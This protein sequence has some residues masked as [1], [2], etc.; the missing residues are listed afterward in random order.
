M[1]TPQELDVGVVHCRH[2]YLLDQGR[3][4]KGRNDADYL[5]NILNRDPS[6]ALRLHCY[7]RILNRAWGKA[8]HMEWARAGALAKRL[9]QTTEPELGSGVGAHGGAFVVQ[10]ASGT[11]QD[12]VDGPVTGLD[13][14]QK[15]LADVQRN[16]KVGLNNV[17]NLV[18]GNI[19]ERLGFPD[20]G[21]VDHASKGLFPDY[22]LHFSELNGIDQIGRD[23]CSGR[24]PSATGGIP[25]NRY[26]RVSVPAE[27]VP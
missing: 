1:P 27:T 2:H 8:G 11:N 23:H 9:S 19:K 10:A 7:L 4:G 20:P 3:L 12:K 24:K 15:G 5:V 18:A 17:I 21:D 14:R 6:C 25:A 22:T 26:N 13:A 16:H